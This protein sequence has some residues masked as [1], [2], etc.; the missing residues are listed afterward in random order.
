[1]TL[2]AAAGLTVRRGGRILLDGLQL[3]ADAGE[4]IAVIGP[5]GAGKS[6]LLSV[7]AGLL[8]PDGG[9]VSLDGRPLTAWPRTA[10][11]RRRSYLPQQLRCEW[12]IAV[13]RLVAL[14]LTPVLPAFGGLS[15]AD[16]ERIN[17][18]LAACDLLPQRAQPATTLSGGELARA[19]LARALVSDPGVLIVDEPIAGLDPRHALDCV[20]QLRQLADS[21]KLV[22]AALHDLTL[23]GRYATRVIALH[24]GRLAADGPPAQVFTPDRL[25]E[26]FGVEARVVEAPGGRYIDFV[27]PA[28]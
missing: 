15:G 4:C 16:Q 6:T 2:L 13:D 11:A 25:R 9:G 10:L 1:M 26:V 23:A 18:V 7:L 19:M 14:G 3:E 17:R 27:G 5:N 22:I 12:P 8:V 21:G 28:G 20:Q 24:G